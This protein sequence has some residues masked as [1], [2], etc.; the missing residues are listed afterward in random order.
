[1]NKYHKAAAYNFLTH[2]NLLFYSLLGVDLMTIICMPLT[3]KATA[4]FIYFL[5]GAVYLVHLL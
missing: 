1:M 4:V 5:V 3:T 2:T